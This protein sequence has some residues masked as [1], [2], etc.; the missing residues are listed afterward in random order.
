MKIDTTLEHVMLLRMASSHSPLRRSSRYL[1]PTSH[2]ESTP[3]AAKRGATVVPFRRDEQRYGELS[4]NVPY[5][6]RVQ[7]LQ[8][9]HEHIMG[10]ILARTA[11]RPRVNTGLG[12]AA[13]GEEETHGEFDFRGC[14]TLSHASEQHGAEVLRTGCQVDAAANQGPRGWV[15]SPYSLVQP[16]RYS[17]GSAPRIHWLAFDQESDVAEVLVVDQHAEV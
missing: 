4:R 6:V 14:G 10:H 2:G 8:H 9:L 11:G 3:T 1:A 15:S 16:S 13:R 7:E 17:W 12:A 5:T